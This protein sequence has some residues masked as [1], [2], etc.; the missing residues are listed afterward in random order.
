MFRILLAGCAG[1]FV[2]FLWGMAAWMVV[3]LHDESV[4]RLPDEATVVEALSEQQLRAGMYVLPAMPEH[5]SEL[6]A[7]EA[8][9]ANERWAARHREG[10]VVSIFYKPQ[11]GEPMPPSVLGAG[12]LIDFMAAVIAA[13]MVSLCDHC[14]HYLPRVGIVCLMGV[15]AALVS[16]AAYWNWMAFPLDHTIAMTIDLVVGWVLAGSVIGLIMRPAGKAS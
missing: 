11:G 12:L 14:R 7:E 8:E 6:S 4:R 13:Y 2:V 9:Q 10:P 5:A 1:A 3:P 15:F 16:H